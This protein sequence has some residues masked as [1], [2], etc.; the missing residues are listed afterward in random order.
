MTTF[1]KIQNDFTHNIIGYSA[2][3][4]ILSTCLGSAAVMTTLMHGHEMLQMLFVMFS[5]VS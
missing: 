3:G 2:I 5:V 1:S 4:I